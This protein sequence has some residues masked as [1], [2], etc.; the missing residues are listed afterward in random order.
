VSRYELILS[1][2]A[3]R[4][5]TERLPEKAAAAAWE[6]ITGPL[7]ENPRRVGKPLDP[8]LAPGWAARRGEY[9]IIYLTD[10]GRITVEVVALA[11]R[12]DASRSV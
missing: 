2:R 9:R 1:R 12:R 8:P 6:F 10:D 3:K 4:D 5:L 11:H 7:L